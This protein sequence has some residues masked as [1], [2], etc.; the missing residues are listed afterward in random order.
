M[1]YLALRRTFARLA[2]R[3][4][5][6]VRRDH[7]STAAECNRHF[8]R[9]RWKLVSK[10]CCAG[11]AAQADEHHEK[12]DSPP[13]LAKANEQRNRAKQ[14]HK[15]SETAVYALLGRHEVCHDC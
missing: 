12:N 8:H 13:V 14:S 2:K 1:L 4:V 5:Q 3:V 15:Q 9:M 11:D 6:P 7:K 10:P